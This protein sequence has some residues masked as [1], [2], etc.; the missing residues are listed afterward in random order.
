MPAPPGWN[1]WKQMS[2]NKRRKLDPC[3]PGSDFEDRCIPFRRLKFN[4]LESVLDFPVSEIAREPGIKA[5]C[6]VA[7]AFLSAFVV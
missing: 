1:F 6:S 4:P 2:M 7:D 3:R 5:S